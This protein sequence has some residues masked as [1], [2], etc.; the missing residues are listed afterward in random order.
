MLKKSPLL[1]TDN[2]AKASLEETRGEHWLKTPWRNLLKSISIII[3]VILIAFCIA[4]EASSL[5][6]QRKKP[7]ARGAKPTPTPTPDMRPEAAQVATQIKNISNFIYIYGKI[8]NTIQVVDDQAKGDQTSPKAQALNKE[9]KDA[10][11]V[12]ISKLRAGLEN[13]SNNFK[14]NP[15]LQVQYL[16]LNFAADAVLNA[17][18][19][20]AAGQYEAAGKM[21][22]TA[23][24]RLTDTIISMRLP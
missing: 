14:A 12:N 1:F 13:L 5:A 18:R 16:K 7:V 4:P 11:V 15:R 10:L 24:E 8:V 20:A 21:L 9:S 2:P 17:E 3:A 19:L 6:Q 23:I 22:V